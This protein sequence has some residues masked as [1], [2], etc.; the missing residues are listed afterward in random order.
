M[1]RIGTR[2]V[3]FPEPSPEVK[4]E[5]PK[6]C[7]PFYDH[8]TQSD[9]DSEAESIL[10]LG[11]DSDT[12]PN[13]SSAEEEVE[14]SDEN[15]DRVDEEEG[16]DLVEHPREWP[17]EEFFEVN[18]DMSRYDG[19]DTEDGF[20]SDEEENKKE[21]SL[22][23]GSSDDQ[24]FENTDGLVYSKR[25]PEQTNADRIYIMYYETEASKVGAIFKNGLKCE[26]LGLLGT[27][28]YVSRQV[29]KKTKK[30]VLKLL[31]YLG[32]FYILI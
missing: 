12:T 32:M 23:P 29:E 27:G 25:R 8:D 26:E 16:R 18:L 6:F 3:T 28:V 13:L 15:N 14:D 24:S 4:V 10:D 5:A 9:S 11:H 19:E 31:A 22:C 1:S 7:Q 21:A 30:V 2:R 17:E 20:T